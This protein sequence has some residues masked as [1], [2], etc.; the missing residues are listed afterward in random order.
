MTHSPSVLTMDADLKYT[1]LHHRYSNAA[2]IQ[3]W[4]SKMMGIS[5]ASPTT[6]LDGTQPLTPPPP[7]EDLTALGNHFL[8]QAPNSDAIIFPADKWAELHAFV[9]NILEMEYTSGSTPALLARK[10][11]SKK[12]PAWLEHVL[13]LSRLR[14]YFTVY[15]GQDTA[16]AIMG[17]HN[18]APFVPD[19]YQGDEEA[20]HDASGD[21][22]E[23]QAT[24]VFDATSHID[25]L[26][27]LPQS[28][29]LPNIHNLPVLTWDGKTSS[30][31][32]LEADADEYVVRFRRDVGQC[33]GKTP[34]PPP[35]KLTNDLFCKPKPSL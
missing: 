25:I 2:M 14:G 15:P 16:N 31:E 19:E 27:T 32:D 13:Q 5:F 30:V 7:S 10:D 21:T 11:V 26:S 4:N 23:D 9:T 24:A 29:N 1:L 6:L 12:Y 17:I 34:R 3:D 8:W 18:D 35:H 33:D 28:G 20:E 22:I